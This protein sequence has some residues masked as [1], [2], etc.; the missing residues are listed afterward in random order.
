M[1][2]GNQCTILWHVNDLKILHVKSN[3]LTSVIALIKGEFGKEALSTVQHGKIHDYLGMTLDFTKKG[4]VVILMTNYIESM[5]DG[6][7]PDMDGVKKTPYLFIVNPD[8]ERLNEGKA[9]VF[10]HYVT[11]TLFCANAGGRIYRQQWLF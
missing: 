1:I 3:V 11:N 9:Q 6:L 4:K 7:D 5:L 10:H 2:D 8:A